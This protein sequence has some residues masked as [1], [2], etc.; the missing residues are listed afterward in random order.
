VSQ[1]YRELA[2]QLRLAGFP[3]KADDILRADNWRDLNCAIC[4]GNWFAVARSCILWLTIGW[5]IGAGYLHALACAFVL[6]AV[7]AEVL[8]G[9]ATVPGQAPRSWSWRMQ[10]SASRFL[11]FKLGKDFDDFFDSADRL[12]APGQRL[13]FLMHA[14]FGFLIAACVAAGVAGFTQA[15]S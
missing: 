12:L 2:T 8:R 7:G 1:P 9:P 3:E 5:G 13:Y 10:A 15:V 14:A 11:P 4:H 6:S